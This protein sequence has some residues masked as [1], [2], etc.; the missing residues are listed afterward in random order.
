MNR[1]GFSLVLCLM[2][3][4]SSVGFVLYRETT[5]TLPAPMNS[6]AYIWQ[7]VWSDALV[8]S[9][10]T[11]NPFIETW[12]I[13]ASEHDQ[14]GNWH[15]SGWGDDVRPVLGRDETAERRAPAYD[16]GARGGSASEPDF[17]QRRAGS[18]VKALA[19]HRVI[20]VF[21]LSGRRPDL[22][23]AE[24]A[25][26]IRA[27]LARWIASGIRVNGVEI[28]HDCA[29]AQLAIYARFLA[30]L[31]ADLAP[32][33]KLTITTLPAWLGASSLPSVLAQA[34]RA[35]LQLHA[36]R[37]PVE[38]LF[39]PAQ[40][41]DSAERFAPI[42]SQYL[43]SH[44]WRIALPSY[45]SLVVWGQDGH[46][47]AVESE[48]SQ[49]IAPGAGQELVVEPTRVAA[50]MRL[51]ESRRPEGLK[52]WIWFRLPVAGDRR[53]W[54][55][56]SWSNLVRH[57]PVREAMSVETQPA[58]QALYHIIVRNAGTI[59]ALPPPVLHVTSPCRGIGA[60]NPY[61]LDYDRAG[62]VLLRT[63][64]RLLPVGQSFIAAWLSCPQ[65]EAPIH[66][67]P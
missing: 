18:I 44:Q 45:G 57:E 31:R 13:L 23:P 39:G 58:G 34:D 28:D 67:T 12:H 54:S 47:A 65:E 35:V 5:V 17:R 8:R 43:R 46:L 53:A 62:P 33:T 10:E 60:Q 55:L 66:V 61:R 56:E 22:D 24:V 20:A 63:Q 27:L 40:A 2:V 3:V 1:R 30:A 29:T 4:L 49:G 52:G 15:D 50:F 19:T 64:T 7:R 11:A 36:V 9:I 42:A 41:R 59:D 37:D 21:R 51:I 26:H 25:S 16:S 38:G 14:N 48:A 6:E 32:G